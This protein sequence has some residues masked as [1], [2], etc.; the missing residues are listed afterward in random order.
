MSDLESDHTSDKEEH[1]RLASFV[2]GVH[3]DLRKKFKSN[4]GDYE[5]IWNDHCQNKDLLITY[6]D[7]MHHLATE[8]WT[9]KS[10]TRIDWCRETA[11]EFFHRGGLKLALEK[12]ERK[13]RYQ[14][15]KARQGHISEEDSTPIESSTEESCGIL[16]SSQESN[17]NV[18][19][20]SDCAGNTT[21]ESGAV[22]HQPQEHNQVLKCDEQYQTVTSVSDSTGITSVTESS[23]KM[24]SSQG[25]FGITSSTDGSNGVLSSPEETNGTH[26][27]SSTP[28]IIVSHPEDAVGHGMMASIACAPESRNLTCSST[29]TLPFEGKIRLLD[30]GSC[31]NPFLQFPEFL[32]VGI[33]ISPAKPSVYR[34]DF[35]H[36][37]TVKPLQVASDTLTTYVNNLRDP[38]EKLPRDIFHMVVFSLLLEYFPSAYQRWLCCQ[39]AHSLL[40]INGLLLI[41]TPDSKTQHKNAGMIKSWRVAIESMGFVRWRYV[42]Q[43]HLHCMAFRKVAKPESDNCLVNDVSPDMLYIPQDFND[44]G[45]DDAILSHYSPFTAEDEDYFRSTM[46]ELP[47]LGSEDD[48]DDSL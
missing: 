9:K 29:I 19:S 32:A 37:E 12:D 45:H 27:G 7:C 20:I 18:S 5:K 16:T 10:K 34:C 43:E 4:H 13:R 6:A 2:K 40:T 11:L 46:S 38:I 26:A 41:I 25:S 15:L 17:G 44:L 8:H 1:K 23:R 47:A 3:A 24:A 14:E 36:L 42:K 31:Y 35:L 30:V 33:D 39:K 21:S 48:C 22:Q 28:D